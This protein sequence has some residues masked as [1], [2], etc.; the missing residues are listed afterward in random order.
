[1]FVEFFSAC[2]LII[3]QNPSIGCLGFGK[4]EKKKD[5]NKQKRKKDKENTNKGDA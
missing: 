3:V 1:M 4:K 2:Y 5:S